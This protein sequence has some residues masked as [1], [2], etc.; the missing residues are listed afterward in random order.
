MGSMQDNVRIR[1]VEHLIRVHDDR[2]RVRVAEALRHEPGDLKFERLRS[3]SR[4][5]GSGSI[6]VVLS[7]SA[8]PTVANT[9]T[10]S[11][12]FPPVF[13]IQLRQ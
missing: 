5:K 9:G 12:S 10:W 1:P 13:L 3:N 8:N 11:M 4:E 7:V 6:P 2:S